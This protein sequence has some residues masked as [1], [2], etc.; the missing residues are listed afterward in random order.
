MRN[1]YRVLAGRILTPIVDDMT[2]AGASCDL[3]FAIRADQSDARRKVMG[4][5]PQCADQGRT[6]SAADVRAGSANPIVQLVL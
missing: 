1:E 3:R 2:V 5:F 4:L 6:V